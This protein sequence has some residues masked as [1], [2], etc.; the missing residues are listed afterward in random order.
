MQ[1]LFFSSNKW[2]K[3]SGA[4]EFVLEKTTIHF[5]G[6]LSF[7]RKPIAANFERARADHAK[8]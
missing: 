8:K 7:Q 2:N 3:K 6:Q 1:S 5:S 4:T